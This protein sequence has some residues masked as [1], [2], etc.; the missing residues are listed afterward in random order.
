M[1]GKTISKLLFWFRGKMDPVEIIH[2]SCDG[3]MA[4]DWHEIVRG[5]II[6]QTAY[7][8]YGSR[9]E[10]V[11]YLVV[12]LEDGSIQHFYRG[13]CMAATPDMA[14]KTQNPEEDLTGKWVYLT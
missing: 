13:Y 3:C 14:A 6:G 1:I 4:T 5:Q 7:P 9:G 12:Q 11:E 10:N 2:F 8:I